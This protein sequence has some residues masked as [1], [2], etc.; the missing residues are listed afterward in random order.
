MPLTSRSTQVVLLCIVDFSSAILAGSCF[1]SRPFEYR[2][3]TH[4]LSKVS[5]LVL[6]FD[7]QRHYITG[8]THQQLFR[9]CT[10][11]ST[12]HFHARIFF[13]SVLT[14]MRW[15]CKQLRNYSSTYQWFLIHYRPIQSVRK[16]ARRA[17]CFHCHVLN[18]SFVTIQLSF[19]LEQSMYPNLWRHLLLLL[20]LRLF[21]SFSFFLFF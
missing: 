5:L 7:L 14:S 11:Y 3:Q 12:Y 2:F 10:S 1:M 18:S 4:R 15:K 20:S 9:T 16:L 8:G 13:L 21:W 6:T 17:T 19:G